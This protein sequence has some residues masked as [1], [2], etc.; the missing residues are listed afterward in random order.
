V[1]VKWPNSKKQVFHHVSADQVMVASISDAVLA[2]PPHEKPVFSNTLFTEITSQSGVSYVHHEIDFVDFNIQ[3]L[4]PHKFSEYGPALAAGDMDGNGLDD[5]VCG[6]SAQHSAQLFFQQ[7]D[8]NSCRNPCCLRVSYPAKPG[9]IPAFC[10]LM[11]MGITTLIFILHQADMNW[12]PTP[13]LPG[14]L[15]Y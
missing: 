9:M 15:L 13:C 14:S 5:I 1:V 7:P 2:Y 3:K 11:L 10:C 8:G 6:G 12:S 4:I